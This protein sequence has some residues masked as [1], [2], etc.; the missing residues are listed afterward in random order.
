MKSHMIAGVIDTLPIHVAGEISKNNLELYTAKT[1]HW[2]HLAYC[3]KSN[4]PQIGCSRSCTQQEVKWAFENLVDEL[5]ELAGVDPVEFRL[6][7]VARPGDRLSPATDWS[8]EFKRPELENGAL[9]YDFSPRSRCWRRAQR[10]FG[11][12]K[13]NSRPGTMPGR[14][15]RGMGMGM[16]QHHPATLAYHEG[17]TAFGTEPGEIWGAEVEMDPAGQVILR[18]ALPDSGTNH[19]TAI[20]ILIAEML[21]ISEIDRIKLIWGTRSSRL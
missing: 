15:K 4:T 17:E 1:P 7:N 13:R 11:W 14:F 20:A 8:H 2:E 3:Y 9:T 18:S 6:I 12:E 16:S 21:G 5:A 10:L 19:S